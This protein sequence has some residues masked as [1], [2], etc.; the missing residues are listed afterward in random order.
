MDA[1]SPLHLYTV[2]SRK[3]VSSGK[4]GLEVVV[5]GDNL[6]AAVVV[7]VGALIG[8]AVNT[9]AAQ[10]NV[11]VGSVFQDCD[12]CPS[13]VVVPAGSFL[14]G[15][16]DTE[17]DR[18]NMYSEGDTAAGPGEN[19]RPP[20]SVTRA[21]VAAREKPQVRITI[22]RPFAIGRYE[23]TVG[24]Y[25]AFVD[26]T[27]YQSIDS[28]SIYNEDGSRFFTALG[29]TWR[30]PGFEQV[31]RSPVVCISWHDATAYAAWVAD[32]TGHSYRLPTEAEWEYAARAG[33]GTARYWGDGINEAC[34]Y[35]NVGDLD[36]ADTFGWHNR[37]FACRDGHATTAPVGSYRPNAW[38]LYDVL[39]NVWELIDD[40][41]NPT[42]A[43]RPT[44]ASARRGPA[45]DTVRMNKGASW[46]HYPW[47]I[48]SAVRN[49]APIE[50]SYNTTGLR[51]VR[52][53]VL[54]D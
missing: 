45:C 54:S 32:L 8:S 47:G 40:C 46:S 41:W 49:R 26:A 30:E 15:S 53:L 5:L 1:D 37:E 3:R 18:E 4:R 9:V 19:G 52:D 16:S 28:C 14:I 27:G 20:V 48:R 22:T 24:Q 51:L 10:T 34:A 6:L 17:T 44:D 25:A 50:A 43:G 31:S 7:M 13:M 11:P 38:G 39:G 33:S 2:L 35:A 36:M 12:V 29:V 42:H 23:V 21:E